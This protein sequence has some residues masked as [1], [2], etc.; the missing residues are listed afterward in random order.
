MPTPFQRPTRLEELYR[1]Q[2]QKLIDAYFVLPSF[3]TLGE[4]NSRLVEYGQAASFFEA[5]ATRLAKRMITQT[6]VLNAVSWRQAASIGSKGQL[7]HRLLQRTLTENFKDQL[8]LLIRE[9]S[10]LIVTLPHKIALQASKYAYQQFTNG[11]RS[12][13]IVKQMRPYMQHLKTWEIRR[14]ARTEV[15]KADTAITRVR[16]GDIGLNWY[17]WKTSHDARVRKS[18]KHLNNVLINWHDPPAPEVLIGEP[19]QG[20]YDAGNTYNCRCVALPLV[21]LDQIAFPVKVY[22]SG[23]I[24]TFSMRQFAMLS[25]MQLRIAA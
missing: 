1:I 18:H 8:N 16:A 20:R 24:Q 13:T 6:A 22:Y 10:Q 17:V 2:I 12:E 11:V 3:A 4:I 25:G 21:R 19:S 5:L 7:I 23:R 14:I 9:N 15:A